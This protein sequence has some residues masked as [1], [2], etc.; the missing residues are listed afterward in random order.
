[1]TQT[2][3]FVLPVDD[4]G[5]AAGTGRF[6]AEL[7]GTPLLSG[8]RVVGRVIEALRVKDRINVTAGVT[9]ALTEQVLA[10][11]GKPPLKLGIR[12][13]EPPA[14]GVI[15]G[16]QGG[17]IE[18]PTTGEVVDKRV[19]WVRDDESGTFEPEAIYLAMARAK[20]DGWSNEQ[21]IAEFDLVGEATNPF[22]LDRALRRGMALLDERIAEGKETAESVVIQ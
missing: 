17:Q 1:M 5:R 6:P 8:R 9:D 20:R 21:I 14:P 4:A 12:R 2:V 7:V 18:L 15:L 11:G 16:P 10:H 19:T 22:V 13:Q 3:D